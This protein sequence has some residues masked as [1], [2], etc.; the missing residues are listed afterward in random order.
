MKKMEVLR[1][2][3]LRRILIGIKALVCLNNITNVE[4][5]ISQRILAFLEKTIRMHHDKIPARLL[6]TYCSG[7]RSVERPNTSSRHSMLKDKVK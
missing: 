5:Q 3:Y 6:S 2:I 7:K 4:N 1:M